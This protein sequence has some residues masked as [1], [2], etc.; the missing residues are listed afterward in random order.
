MDLHTPYGG[1]REPPPRASEVGRIPFPPLTPYFGQATPG[2]TSSTSSQ[3]PRQDSAVSNI[4]SA[5]RG[6]CSDAG[7]PLATPGPCPRIP[8]PEQLPPPVMATP[9]L[10]AGP[11][12]AERGPPRAAVAA[13]LALPVRLDLPPDPPPAPAPNLVASAAGPRGRHAGRGTGHVRGL[14]RLSASS[15]AEPAALDSSAASLSAASLAGVRRPSSAAAEPHAALRAGDASAGRGGALRAQQWVPMRARPAGSAGAVGA[16]RLRLSSPSGASTAVHS[17]EDRPAAAAACDAEDVAAAPDDDGPVSLLAAARVALRALRLETPPLTVPYA[18]PTPPPTLAAPLA[19]EAAGIGR[20]RAAAERLQRLARLREAAA[21]L[22]VEPAAQ[23]GSR[24]ELGSGQQGY[25]V[26]AVAPLLDTG[27]EA[28]SERGLL[29]GPRDR[30]AGP[31]ATPS[32]PPDS[33]GLRGRVDGGG[34]STGD[35]AG[36]SRMDVEGTKAEGP[37]T[38]GVREAV[39]GGCVEA[40]ARNVA[41]ARAATASTGILHALVAASPEAREALLAVRPGAVAQLARA[42]TGTSASLSASSLGVLRAL[43]ASPDTRGRVLRSARAWDWAAL[44]RT[45]R[46]QQELALCGGRQAATEAA[47]LMAALLAPRASLPPRPGS[48]TQ[49]RFA[50][51]AAK[52]MDRASNRPQSAP[53]AASVGLPSEDHAEAQVQASGCLRLLSLSDACKRDIAAAGGVAVLAPLLSSPNESA[54]SNAR[55]TLAQLPELAAPM[56]AAG[57][58]VYIHA[59]NLQRPARPQRPATAPP[60]LAA[61]LAELAAA[62]A[63]TVRRQLRAATAPADA[64]RSFSPASGSAD[65][66]ARVGDAALHAEV[67]GL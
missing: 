16:G 14:S 18:M 34:V 19:E 59:A 25:Q 33:R 61:Q 45:L 17:M 44:M 26:S 6:A 43:A 57:L 36:A 13:P 37:V 2:T 51:F 9:V 29:A 24:S 23:L 27:D 39:K 56:R 66:G 8:S 55:Q 38:A 28:I 35:L 47:Q 67:L 41:R 52:W 20:P 49:Q 11:R 40:A 53:G 21:P 65:A 5:P 63:G 30:A 7:S 3:L 50:D 31:P 4:A 48:A 54:R 58:P 60:A 64:W 62:R 15:L 42:A 10:P 46:M 32:V 12:Q 22:V 1:W